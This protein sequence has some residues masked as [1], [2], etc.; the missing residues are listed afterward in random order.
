MELTRRGA[1]LVPRASEDLAETIDRLLDDPAAR[2]Q[3]AA[4]GCKIAALDTEAI[5]L[6]V[7]DPPGY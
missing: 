1:V 7:L 2:E 3:A 6:A 5:A 4:Q